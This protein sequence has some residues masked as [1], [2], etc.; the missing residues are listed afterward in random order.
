MEKGKPGHSVES[1]GGQAQG[2]T[3]VEAACVVRYIRASAWSQ[4]ELQQM[5]SADGL[6]AWWLAEFSSLPFSV[7][8]LIGGD[9]DNTIS[10]DAGLV[11]GPCWVTTC[12]PI[13]V[14][15]VEQICCRPR[16][17]EVQ[18]RRAQSRYLR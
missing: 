7:R 14:N 10:I 2:R 15:P 1:L 12:S 9:S 11:P 13:Q 8:Q 17:R 5:E 6:V 3:N 4:I 18:K 16:M